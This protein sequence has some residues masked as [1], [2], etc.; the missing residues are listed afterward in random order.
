MKKLDNHYSYN[1]SLVDKWFCKNVDI[2]IPVKYLAQHMS[3]NNSFFFLLI[4]TCS[5]T[6]FYQ[7]KW[8]KYTASRAYA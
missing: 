4:P 5:I 6:F 8:K 2:F 1:P 7:I 3:W